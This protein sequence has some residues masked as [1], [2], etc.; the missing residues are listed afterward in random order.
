MKKLK[1]LRI[2]GKWKKEQVGIEDVVL[3]HLIFLGE[4]KPLSLE[5]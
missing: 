1:C 2:Q 5:I 4:K 3:K